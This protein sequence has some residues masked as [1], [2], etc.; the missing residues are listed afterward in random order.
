MN[1]FSRFSILKNERLQRKSRKVLIEIQDEEYF[2]LNNEILTNALT[3]LLI[4][5]D[6]ITL[7]KTFKKSAS[8]RVNG[9]YNRKLEEREVVSQLD[10]DRKVYK[11]GM[12][13]NYRVFKKPFVSIPFLVFIKI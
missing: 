4:N 1:L 8:M 12:D 10:M 5:L 13:V 2:L 11:A 9:K 6:F 3:Y 7:K